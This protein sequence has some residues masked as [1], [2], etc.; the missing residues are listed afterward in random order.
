MGAHNHVSGFLN[1]G[2]MDISGWVIPCCRGLS[3]T[4][5]DVHSIE[6]SRRGKITPG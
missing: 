1:L 4:V 5:Q 3:D 2:V 6:G